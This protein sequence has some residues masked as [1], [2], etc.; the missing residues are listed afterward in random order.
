MLHIKIKCS[1]VY[2]PEVSE[3][4]GVSLQDE[5]AKVIDFKTFLDGASATS[6][7]MIGYGGSLFGMIAADKRLAR[8][9][10]SLHH[11]H[12]LRDLSYYYFKAGSHNIIKVGGSLIRDDAVAIV[13]VPSQQ[14]YNSNFFMFFTRYSF[15]NTFKG[16]RGKYVQK[17]V[18]YS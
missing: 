1:S 8:I 14:G 7:N 13:G 5:F 12:L 4:L 9:Q 15:E 11:P 10:K 6:P 2:C 18:R 3:K 16:M 17:S